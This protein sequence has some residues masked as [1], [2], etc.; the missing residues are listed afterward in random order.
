MVNRPDRLRHH[1]IVRS[2]NQN[3]D[4]GNP[5]PRAHQRKRFV[6]RSIEENNAAPLRL[7]DR[8]R[9]CV[10]PSFLGRHISPES[11]QQRC[12]PVIDV[13]HDSYSPEVG[14]I[15]GWIIGHLLFRLS[16]L[17]EADN[18]RLENQ[19]Q[20]RPP[21]QRRDH[22]WLIEARMPLAISPDDVLDLM[23]IFSQLLSVTPRDGDGLSPP[24]T[25]AAAE[26][27]HSRDPFGCLHSPPGLF[28]PTSLMMK[29]RTL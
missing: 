7:P 6:T 1:T 13:P 5:A 9:C 27:D 28:L 12:F 22:A 4:I 14:P 2:H 29:H 23:S 21:W 26:A 8:R 10:I 19:T 18:L 24:A 3:D 16:F 15:V 17:F 20:R 11:H 25:Q